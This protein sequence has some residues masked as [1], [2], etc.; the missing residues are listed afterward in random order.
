MSNKEPFIK[1]LGFGAG[2]R[3]SHRSR[4]LQAPTKLDWLE[5]IS[6]NY[7]GMAGRDPSPAILTLEKLRQDYPIAMHGVCM[8]IGSADALDMNYLKRLK[9]IADRVEPKI[10]SDHICWTGVGGQNLHELLPLPYRGDVVRY[11]VDRIKKVQDF[12]GRRILLENVS[13]YMTFNHSEM[14]EWEFITEL[15]TRA[16]CG[17]LLDVNNIYVSSQNHKFD[18][19]SFLNG[20]PA[21]RVGQI[22]LAGHTKE[23]GVLIDTHDHP[24]PDPVWVLYEKANKLFG[25]VST[26]VEW[27]DKIPEIEVLEAEVLKAKTFSQRKVYEQTP[28]LSL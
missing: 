4:F 3:R 23:N 1:N 11:V 25:P 20:V 15:S 22:H 2:F 9:A 26:M 24:V 27:D 6:E 5:V 10:I 13:S 19:E 16:D 12:L 17:I 28:T 18:A 7:L 8:S 14:E 21:N